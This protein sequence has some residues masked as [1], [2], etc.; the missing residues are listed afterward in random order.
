MFLRKENS[1]D[2]IL[3]DRDELSLPDYKGS[4]SNIRCRRD[5]VRSGGSYKGQAYGK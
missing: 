3:D 5:P 2:W 4:K 1:N